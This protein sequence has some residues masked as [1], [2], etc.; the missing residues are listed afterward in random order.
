MRLVIAVTNHNLLTVLF[1]PIV[2]REERVE[3]SETLDRMNHKY[4]IRTVGLNVAGSDR[5]AWK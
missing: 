4:G 2:R 3:L 1:D 5:E